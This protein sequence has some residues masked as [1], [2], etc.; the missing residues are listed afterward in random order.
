M[1]VGGLYGGGRGW[2]KGEV[3]GA[4]GEGRGWME[5]GEAGGVDVGGSGWRKGEVDGGERGWRRRDSWMGN[6]AVF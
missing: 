2:R 1:G 6:N 5:V 4:G 3:G